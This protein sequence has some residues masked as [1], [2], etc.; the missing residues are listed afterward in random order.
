[1]HAL[2][3]GTEKENKRHWEKNS[4]QKK[5]LRM[6]FIEIKKEKFTFLQDG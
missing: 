3:K 6:H 1:M 4:I 2:P 5:K